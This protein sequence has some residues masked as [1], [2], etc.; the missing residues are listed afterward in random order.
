MYQLFLILQNW[1]HCKKDP[2]C[3]QKLFIKELFNAKIHLNLGGGICA[4]QSLLCI[5]IG[6]DKASVEQLGVSGK[7][8]QYNYGKIDS[9][10]SSITMPVFLTASAAILSITTLVFLITS[11]ATPSMTMSISSTTSPITL[12]KI[13]YSGNMPYDN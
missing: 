4:G 2:V 8:S 10:I 1:Q 12:P 13:N 9:N 7:K 5:S 6:F 3:S 11:V